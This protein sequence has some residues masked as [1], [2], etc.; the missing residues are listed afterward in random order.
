M[1]EVCTL[2]LFIVT[3]VI[4]IVVIVTVVIVVVVE[5][6][7]GTEIAAD[8]AL[9]FAEVTGASLLLQDLSNQTLMPEYPFLCHCTLL[10]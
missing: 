7:S 3:V 8:V 6:P 10:K 5:T 2:V 4:V 1:G 9:R